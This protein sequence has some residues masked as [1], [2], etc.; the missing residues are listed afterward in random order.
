L[1][2]SGGEAD[3]VIWWCPK[4]EKRLRAGRGRTD[5]HPL[6]AVGDIL[7]SESV[8]AEL[9]R[10]M[11]DRAYGPLPLDLL[12]PGVLRAQEQRR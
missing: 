11:N 2:R 8:S 4:V 10:V 3:P 5:A 6:I 1:A 7:E 9:P 12:D